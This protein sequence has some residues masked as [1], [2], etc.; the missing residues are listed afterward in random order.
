MLRSSLFNIPDKGRMTIIH[1]KQILVICRP[2]HQKQ[3][4]EE[5]EEQEEERKQQ[6][7][8]KMQQQ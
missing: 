5:Q 3:Q 1:T 6:I 4:Q 7:I 2:L 8:N